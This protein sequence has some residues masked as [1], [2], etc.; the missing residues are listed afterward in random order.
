[1]ALKRATMTVTVRST[2]STSAVVPAMREGGEG[3]AFGGKLV[4]MVAEV[5]ASAP[6]QT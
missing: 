1:L 3:G 4:A 5:L 2:V 6:G